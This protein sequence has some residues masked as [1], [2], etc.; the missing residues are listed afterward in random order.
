MKISKKNFKNKENQ[1]S[2]F[3]NEE[4]IKSDLKYDLV[5]S[6]RYYLPTT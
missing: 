2:N 3:D 6:F 1:L 4:L 5:K